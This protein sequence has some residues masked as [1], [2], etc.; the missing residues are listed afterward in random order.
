MA[1]E[2]LI[3]QQFTFSPLNTRGV[4]R[5]DPFPPSVSWPMD[6]SSTNGHQLISLNFPNLKANL[7]TSITFTWWSRTKVNY[8]PH[9][10]LDLL[11]TNRPSL[12]LSLSRTVP[13]RRTA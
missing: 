5:F 4:P 13:N 8:L 1:R 7:T 3:D 6:Q 9:I 12:S 10:S 11:A 2:L